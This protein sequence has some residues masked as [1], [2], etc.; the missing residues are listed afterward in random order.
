MTPAADVMALVVG[1]GNP[2]R[3]DDGVGAEVA[4]RVTARGLAGVLVAHYREP[5]QLLDDR[6]DAGI[7]V[8]VDAL[9]SGAPPGSVTVREVD[10]RPLQEWTGTGGTHSVGVVAV[11]ELA[12]ALGRLPRR[13]FLVGVEA[14][15]FDP[16]GPLSPAVA[17]AV[18]EAAEAV[19]TLVQQAGDGR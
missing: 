13:L 17:A 1:V 12:R 6:P 3:G 10:D 7:V 19:V 5:V 8:I 9:L 11:V 4:R 15:A 16:G 14:E 18:E 2:E